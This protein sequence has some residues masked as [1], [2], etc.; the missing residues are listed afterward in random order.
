M[1]NSEMKISGRCPKCD[2]CYGECRCHHLTEE[3]FKKF[4]SEPLALMVP[5][6]KRNMDASGALG[7]ILRWYDAG[8]GSGSHLAEALALPP[9]QNIRAL[10]NILTCANESPEVQRMLAAL[11]E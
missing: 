10:A 7:E 9:S 11:A 4:A 2:K 5:V 3:D 8:C 6:P 1:N